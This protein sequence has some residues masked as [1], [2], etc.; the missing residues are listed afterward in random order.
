MVM[1]LNLTKSRLTTANLYGE[2][3][4][5]AGLGTV[6]SVGAGNGILPAPNPIVGAGTLGLTALTS[7]WNAGQYRIDSQNSTR[8]FNLAALGADPTGVADCAAIVNAAFVAFG[9]GYYY[10][11]KGTYKVAS[12]LNIAT[13]GI[14]IVGDGKG[15]TN[16]NFV[17]A[18]ADTLFYF[19]AGAAT[20]NNCGISELTIQSSDVAVTKVGI[21]VSDAVNFD[22]SQITFTGGWTGASSIAI[23]ISGRQSIRVSNVF[24][25]D[26][27]LPVVIGI[28]P[29]SASLSF[30][31]SSIEESELVVT[32]GLNNAVITVTDGAGMTNASFRHIAIVRGGPGISMNNTLMAIAYNSIRIEDF[33]SEQGNDATAYSIDLRSSLAG[34]QNLCIVDGLFDPNRKGIRLSLCQWP[35]VEAVAY[36]GVGEFLNLA[37][38]VTGFTIRNSFRQAGSTITDLSLNPS[39]IGLITGAN[40]PSNT[41]GTLTNTANALNVSGTLT[42]TAIGAGTTTATVPLD[43]GGAQRHRGIAAPAV[44]EVNSGRI[45]FDSALNK[46]RVS[47]N[48]GAY[49][50]LVGSAGLTGSGVAGRLPY[51]TAATN[52]S[53]DG[54]LYVDPVGHRLGLNVPVPVY[55]LDMDGDINQTTGSVL[56]VNALPVYRADAGSGIVAAGQGINA[57]LGAGATVVGDGACAAAMAGAENTVVGIAAAP[58][59]AA[60]TRNSCVGSGALQGTTSGNDNVG[61]GRMAGF[62]NTTG[63]QNVL[64]GNASDVGAGN[65]TNAVAIGYNASV[66]ASDSMVLGNAAMKVGIHTSAPDQALDVN[67][68]VATRHLDIVLAGG[69]NED[70]ALTDSS[71][72]R[73]TG[74]VGAFSLG[75]F[76]NGTDGRHLTVLNTTAQAMTIKNLSGGSAAANQILTL[77]GA[78]VVLPARTSSATFIYEDTQDKWILTATS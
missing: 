33:R 31:H 61:F 41:F 71:W 48:G 26:A 53:N 17:P 68:A 34:I 70:I 42:A 62:S 56:R 1:S 36:G 35:F 30:D 16:I 28:N 8:W 38:N 44:S 3:A 73:I 27:D 66:A 76:A 46:Y 2:P 52:L 59:L 20:I 77:T 65:L 74:P 64:L 5:G 58:V 21:D 49:V 78:D 54:S 39:A 72:I 69:A 25:N 18:G 32:A 12:T 67:G 14:Q 47:M 75:G 37:V 57:T 40:P 43:V 9:A 60:G 15:I 63:S 13:A 6:T 4:A 11:P 24:I 50:D 7:D 23:R 45:Y 19:S 29:N 55:R 51:W 22:C 10:F